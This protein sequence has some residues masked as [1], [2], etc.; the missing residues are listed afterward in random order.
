MIDQGPHLNGDY[1][2]AADQRLSQSIIWEIQ[3]R[4]FLR[5]GIR[6]WLENIIPSHIS[7]SPVMVRAYSQVVWGYLRDC[8]AAGADFSL[9][10]DQPIYIVELGAGSGRLAY[11]FLH[12]FLPRYKNSPFD[13]PPIKFVM[14]DFVPEILQF[15]QN[16]ER[17]RPYVQSGLLDFALFDVMETRPLT[18]INNN[19][20]L[21]PDQMTNPLILIANY[22]FDSIPQDSFML[23]EGQ[24]CQNLLTLY[25][26]QPEPDLAEA[27]IWER[28]ALAYEA[29]PL[30]KPYYQEESYNQILD[31]YEAQ[32]PDTM[33]TF[34][35]VGLDCVRFWQGFGSGRLLLLTSDR[36]YTLAE[37]MLDLNAPLPNLH[38]SFS[39]MVNYHAIS[40]YVEMSGGLALHP[41]HYQDNLQ[42]LAY[43][44]GARPQ[45]VLETRHTFTEAVVQG[46]PDDFYALKLALEDYTHTFTLAQ[47][48]SY[49]R[50]SG[51]DAE[52][53]MACFPALLTQVRRES[54]VWYADV[55]AVVVQVWL[56]YLPLSEDDD[57]AAKIILLL[58]EMGCSAAEAAVLGLV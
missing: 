36:G 22:F 24:L 48:L 23:E 51:Y 25:S 8:A 14:T 52:I 20:T 17:L 57:V 49:L 6:P 4:Y 33:L 18:L 34:P 15:W 16:H 30:E 37:S 10:T 43:V 12:H 44:L 9:D 27:T 32:L 50:L 26:S 7:S 40:Q 35:N 28:L 11:H 5:N 31:S 47:I 41:D 53:F 42:V 21:T 39:L 1:I 2:I 19:L 38:G 3:R 29:I 55:Y 46:G 13:L 56:Q 45:N 54:D 58:N